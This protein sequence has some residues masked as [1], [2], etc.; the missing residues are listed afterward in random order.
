M[1][2]KATFLD[3]IIK[4]LKT[5]DIVNII[6]KVGTGKSSLTMNI[7]KNVVMNSN[8]NVAMFS[9]GTTSVSL[10]PL[11]IKMK[12]NKLNIFINKTDFEKDKEIDE[13]TSKGF[14]YLYDGASV[15]IEKIKQ[16]VDSLIK[17]LKRRGQ[18][19]DFILIDYLQLT[20]TL[21]L[22]VDTNFNK[23]AE[24]NINK[25]REIAVNYNIPIILVTMLS[26]NEK[27]EIEQNKIIKENSD[28]VIELERQKDNSQIT[29]I[30]SKN[31]TEIINCKFDKNLCEFI[32]KKEDNNE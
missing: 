23:I 8:K 27:K 5:M 21:N 24:E 1:E 29:I 30:N 16:Q 11:L 3:E 13:E 9:L 26:D 4:D 19:L 22:P 20:Y 6:G 14:F 25:I 10:I 28:I 7:I 12:I 15:T 2:G 17:E 18:K 32:Q 31:K